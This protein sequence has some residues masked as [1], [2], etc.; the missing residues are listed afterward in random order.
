MKRLILTTSDSGSGSIGATGLADFV[1]TL[2]R[3]FAWG[4]LPSGAQ[5][6]AFFSARTA[7]ERGLH[8]QDFTPARRF[9]K[10]GGKDL[11]LIEFCARYESVE[12]WIDPDPNAQLNLLWLLD[13]LYADEK[14][15]SKV[16]FVQ[17]DFPHGRMH[18]ER[19]G[20]LAWTACRRDRESS[21]NGPCGV[22][23]LSRTDPS[24]LVQAA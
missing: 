5:L 17:A 4:P 16:K 3:R 22:A 10:P 7:Q 2:E 13:Y 9:E 18:T 23:G 11:G 6:E 15:V 24:G 19:V 1:I 8:W 14:L 20:K 12:L 21:R